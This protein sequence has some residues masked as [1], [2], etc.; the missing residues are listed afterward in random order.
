MPPRTAPHRTAPHRT[1]PPCQCRYAP[2]DPV[3]CK[4]LKYNETEWTLWDR[5]NITTEMTLQ[6]FLKWFQVCDVAVLPL[7]TILLLF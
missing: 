3:G 2:A 1:A 6:Q 7:C 4:K 5:F